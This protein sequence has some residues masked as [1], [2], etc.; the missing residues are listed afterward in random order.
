MRFGIMAMQWDYLIPGD[1]DADRAIAHVMGFDPAELVRS[2]AVPPFKTVELGGDMALFLPHTF[3]QDS[4]QKLAELKDEIGLTYTVHLP[5]WS[6]EPSTPLTPVREGSVCALINCIRATLPLEPENFVLHATGALAAEF[7]RINFP[8]LARDYLMRQFQSGA[9]QSIKTILEETGIPSRQLAVE[10]I[11]FPF[12]L[13]LELAEELDLSVCLDAGHILVGFSGLI[14]LEE[15]LEQC[16][17]RLAEVHFHDGPWQGPERSIGYGKDHQPLGAGDLPV[18][19]FLDRLDNAGFTG[20]LIFE[21][22]MQEAL[23]SLEVVR[24]VRPEL[25]SG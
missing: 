5:C 13:T 10:T 16:L 23:Q 4:I 2:L 3:Q 20:P 25:I 12:E 1:L 17:P 11:E 6:V 8:D 7:T 22:R 9:Y 15:A 24:R 14:T 18:A 19:D 21:L